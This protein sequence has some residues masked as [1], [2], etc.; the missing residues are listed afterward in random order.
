MINHFKGCTA[1]GAVKGAPNQKKGKTKTQEE[2]GSA[3]R[4]GK[5]L[6]FDLLDV[7]IS[8]SRCCIRRVKR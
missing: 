6:T 3:T 8:G 1:F 7:Q 4:H 5:S 2:G